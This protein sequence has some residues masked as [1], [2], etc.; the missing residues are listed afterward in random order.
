MSQAGIINT[1]SAPSPPAVPTS[2]VTDVNSP[3]VPLANIENIKGG[4]STTNNSNG[5]QTDG[6]SGSNTLTIQLTNRATGSNTTAGAVTS[7][8]IT[9]ALGA[10]P[11]VYTFDIAVAGF[12]AVTPAG[13]GFTIVGSV[14]TTGAAAVLITNQAVDHFE[15]PALVTATAVLAVSGNNALVNVTGVAGLNIDWQATLTYTLAT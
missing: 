4:T 1:T 10:V 6:S 5:I 9:L 12:N 8:V 7:A 15:E 2:F 3:S 11:G 14:R 13:C